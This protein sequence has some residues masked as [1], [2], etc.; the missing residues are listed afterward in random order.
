MNGF[1]RLAIR[2][3]LSMSME[4]ARETLGFPPGYAPSSDEVTKA[5]RRKAIE[6]HPDRGGSHEKMVEINV[7]KEVLEGKRH[8][9]FR[10]SPAPK[11]KKTPEEEE[12]EFRER[13]LQKALNDLKEEGIDVMGYLKFALTRSAPDLVRGGT[14]IAIKKFLT[15]GY[16]D[17]LDQISNEIDQSPQ[18][19]EK[20]WQ[21]A[22]K[23][24]QNLASKALRLGSQFAAL[25]KKRAAVVKAA[26][27]DENNPRFLP[28]TEGVRLGEVEDLVKDTAKFIAAWSALYVESGKLMSLINTSE[29]VPMAWDD[30]YHKSH[31]IIL[32]FNSGFKS[33]DDSDFQDFKNRVN[34]SVKTVD[35]ILG[36]FGAKAPSIQDWRCPADYHWAMEVIQK[37]NPKN[38]SVARQV[39]A[40]W[41]TL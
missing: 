35:K 33:V 23:L 26:G 1:E 21:T 32:E 30:L 14:L 15:D 17:V 28:N 29:N 5:Y 31:Q 13:K 18:K 8:D 12:R 6:N 37:A 22:D 10:P 39:A 24:C 7:A 40:K 11:P 3:L 41:R 9:R 36:D 34:E 20:D 27:I 2:L 4:E 25:Q 19:G 38:A 16:A